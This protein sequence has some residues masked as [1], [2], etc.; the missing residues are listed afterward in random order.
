MIVLHGN[1]DNISIRT[2]RR[3]RENIKYWKSATT[4]KLTSEA[5]RERRDRVEPGKEQEMFGCEAHTIIANMA[6]G[7]YYIFYLA[8]I[9]LISTLDPTG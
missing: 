2:P 6:R 1:V 3:S 7:I 5:R 9:P 8:T 4:A